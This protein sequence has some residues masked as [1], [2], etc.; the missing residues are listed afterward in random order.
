MWHV[1]AVFFPIPSNFG[2]ENVSRKRGEGTVMTMANPKKD[3]AVPIFHYHY[4]MIGQIPFSPF[5]TKWSFVL[6]IV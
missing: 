6:P 4:D 5:L 3:K 2:K 1:K